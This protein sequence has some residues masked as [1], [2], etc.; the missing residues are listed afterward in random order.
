MLGIH[1]KGTRIERDMYPNV[2]HSTEAAQGAPRDPRRDSRGERSPWLPLE[3]RPD[4]PCRWPLELL[5][6][7]QAPRENVRDWGAWWAAAYGVAQSRTQLKQL[8]SSSS[9]SNGDADIEKRLV[10]T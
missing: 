6:G 9:S 2:H 7:S 4:S 5:R 8:S 10:D 1:T 3:T